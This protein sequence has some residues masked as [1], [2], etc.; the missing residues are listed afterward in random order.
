MPLVP[1]PSPGTLKRG[2]SE[3][4]GQIIVLLPHC[5]KQ[6]NTF[7][8]TTP[9]PYIKKGN[10]AVRRSLVSTSSFT[11]ARDKDLDQDLCGLRISF[12]KFMVGC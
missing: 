8:R 9:S 3:N 12:L 2:D 10:R 7:R 4:T 11:P 5:Q 6:Q 1:S